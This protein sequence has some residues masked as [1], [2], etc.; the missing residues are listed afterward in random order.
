MASLLFLS[1]AQSA[2]AFQDS[3]P[4]S[5]LLEDVALEAAAGEQAAEQIAPRWQSFDPKFVENVCPFPN[6]FKFDRSTVICGYV[7]VPEDRTDPDSRLIRLS[8]MKIPSTATNP[9]GGTVVRLDGGPGGPGV[10]AERVAY[11]AEPQAA[12][13][14]AVAD[15]IYFD[16]RGVGYSEAALC[17]GIGDAWRYG[18]PVAPDGV[19]FYQ[20]RVRECLAEARAAGV[21][22]DAYSTWHNALDV[23]DIRRALGLEQWSVFGVSYGTQLAQAVAQVDPEGVRALVL[24]SVVPAATGSIFGWGAVSAGFNSSLDAVSAACSADEA[25]A[26]DVGDLKGRLRAAIATFDAE[27]MIIEGPELAPSG[28]TRYV[29]DGRLA[30]MFIFQI[31]YDRGFYGDLPVLLEAMETRNDS[32][33]RAYVSAAARPLTL[34]YGQGLYVVASCRGSAVVSPEQTG[35]LAEADPEAARWLETTDPTPTCEAAYKIAPDPAMKRLV[36]DIPTLLGQGLADPVTPPS[37]ADAVM[38]G[39]SRA[40]RVD[41]PH[42]GHGVFV[43][44]LDG[45]SGA[46]LKAFLADPEA[47]LDI[48]CAANMPAPDFVTKWRATGAPYKLY[49]SVDAGALPYAPI[50]IIAALVIALIS[51]PLGFVGR[52]IDGEK[53]PRRSPATGRARLAAF[54]GAALAAAAIGLA[55]MMT[56]NWATA[57]PL[58]LPIGLPPQIGIA[59]WIAVA[60]ALLSA[61]GVFAGVTARLAGRATTGAAVGSALTAAAA[62]GALILLVSLGAGPV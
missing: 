14:R 8:V 15:L 37:G 29:L 25:C 21:A 19:E 54:A 43:D 42:Y 55:A 39:L 4:D 58:A 2:S 47:T 57:H 46:I 20:Q 48:S 34:A 27:P 9:P 51:F 35:A 30:A 62:I 49:K 3:S 18:V 50:A 22:V 28:A 36:T 56:M 12:S 16:Q 44:D 24:D 45:C 41:F 40:T 38:P 5:P 10:Y 59:G 11:L 61:Y 13:F 7:M 60:G 32:A 53:S 6:P 26:R 31:L 33:F 1:V 52:L 17:R 23:R